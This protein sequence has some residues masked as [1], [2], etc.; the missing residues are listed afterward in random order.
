LKAEDPEEGVD[1]AAL[2]AQ[3]EKLRQRQQQKQELQPKL[4][5][6]GEKQVTAVDEDARL[7]KKPGQ[8]GCGDNSQIA[9]G[10]ENHLIVATAVTQDGNDLNQ[11]APMMEA[12]SEAVDKRTGRQ[13]LLPCHAAGGV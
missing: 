2:A 6:Q 1:L 3:I 12:A 9:V 13:W 8:T 11:L 4:P 5:E 7:L 10:D